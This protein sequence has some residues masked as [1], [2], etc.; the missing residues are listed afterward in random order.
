[1]GFILHY[2]H[3]NSTKE[4][5]GLYLDGEDDPAFRLILEDGIG[6]P[7]IRNWLRDPS[8]SSSERLAR[9]RRYRSEVLENACI[10]NY[11]QMV[12]AHGGYQNDEIPEHFYHESEFGFRYELD[13]NRPKRSLL[14][15]RAAHPG[16]IGVFRG[17]EAITRDQLSLY[18]QPDQLKIRTLVH[19]T[20]IRG[21]DS[22]HF[23]NYRAAYHYVRS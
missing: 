15:G 6:G 1:V 16:E 7:E 8:V 10:I 22:P 5:V 4:S 17:F 20:A 12:F 9:R 14:F 3:T 21:S 11:L 13:V 23:A 2:T 19:P 18:Y